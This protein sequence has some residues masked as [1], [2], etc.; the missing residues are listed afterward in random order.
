MQPGTF[1]F[2]FFRG[3]F[4]GIRD[5]MSVFSFR[6]SVTCFVFVLVQIYRLCEVR[7]MEGSLPVTAGASSDGTHFDRICL[8]GPPLHKLG[9]S[10]RAIPPFY[11]Q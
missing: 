5:R 4:S 6:H 10:H 8:P 1:F 9:Q 3:S 7:C 2:S 11:C